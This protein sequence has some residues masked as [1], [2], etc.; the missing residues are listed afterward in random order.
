M[1]HPSDVLEWIDGIDAAI[2]AG[3]EPS[4][5]EMQF[6][7]SIAKVV[8]GLDDDAEQVPL[9][10]QQLASLKELHDRVAE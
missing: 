4:A 7:E 8:E 10:D 9:S 3:Y 1:Y 2:D 6:L 5:W